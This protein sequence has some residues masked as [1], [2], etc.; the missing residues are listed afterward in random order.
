M[1]IAQDRGLLDFVPTPLLFPGMAISAILVIAG[2][3]LNEKA[4]H[5]CR[6][7]HKT[8]KRSLMFL[9][10]FLIGGAFVGLLLWYVTVRVSEHPIDS[11]KTATMT[12][13]DLE[14]WAD[15]PDKRKIIEDLRL[16]YVQSHA[17]CPE[18][19]KGGMNGPPEE[20]TNNRLK[21]M[22][23]PWRYKRLGRVMVGGVDDDG[24]LIGFSITGG[25][26]NVIEDS[27]IDSYYGRLKKGYEIKDAEDASMKRN[28]IGGPATTPS[29]T[30]DT[31]SP[32]PK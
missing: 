15:D 30:P 21:E 29:S 26:N 3:A 23:L 8:P 1:Y 2:L 20:W 17:D 24:G 9:A 11:Q 12:Q 27:V 31:G 5:Y 4:Q 22:G 16:E 25:K 32:P 18:S 10:L 19:I 6:W 14:A 7:I 13:S 28:R